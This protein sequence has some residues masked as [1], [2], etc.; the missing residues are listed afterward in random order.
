MRRR[1]TVLLC[2]LAPVAVLLTLILTDM[3]TVHS[4]DAMNRLALTYAIGLLLWAVLVLSADYVTRLMKT[5]KG[6]DP[7]MV[8]NLVTVTALA[9]TIVLPVAGMA[10]G[11]ES[12]LAN[13]ENRVLA[14]MP[15]LKIDTITSLPGAF[16]SYF[17]DHFGF[18][19][20]LVKWNSIVR[21]KYLKT[22]T[23]PDVILGKNQWLFYRPGVDD[24]RGLTS[25]SKGQLD[26]TSYSIQNKRDWLG[27]RGIHY[28][29]VIV[30]NK[31]TIYPEY[32]PETATRVR[33]ETKLDQFL[34]H[35]EANWD[36][37]VLD[38]RDSLLRAKAQ[39][40]V[41]YRTDTHWNDYGAFVTYCEI[42]KELTEHFPG[43]QFPSIAEYDVVRDGASYSGDLAKMLAMPEV[44]KESEA[45]KVI[46]KTDWTS[47]QVRVK[48]AVVFRDSFF[49]TLEPYLSPHFEDVVV[50]PMWGRFDWALV[51]REQPDVV[52]STSVEREFDERLGPSA[53]E[54]LSSSPS[55]SGT[56]CDR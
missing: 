15:Q 23:S 31:E 33:Q 6:I 53:C 19:G 28:L 41:Y 22:S 35:L 49:D 51:E 1:L 5:L 27:E 10:T 52:I 47:S 50:A 29:V 26:D 4:V 9:L 36:M 37:E 45:P 7:R 18:R 16:E 24:F 14:E 46:L 11:A 44:F 8:S 55:A 21:V 32:L 13:F 42:M 48:K 17:N 54:E 38:V 30:P 43:L 25:L 3:K 56:R 2:F 39:Y 34:G 20:A 12:R 40:P